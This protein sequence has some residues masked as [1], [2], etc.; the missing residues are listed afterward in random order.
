MKKN[1]FYRED[2]PK[3]FNKKN[4]IGVELG[5]AR[6]DFS[7]ELLKSKK[8]KLLFG[9]DSYSLN[10]HNIDE[11]KFALKNVGLFDNYKLLNMKFEDAL[12]L[13]PDR[14]LDFIYFDGYA[15]TG[16][17]YGKT[18]IKWSKK[19]K[20]NG[21]L[22][23]DDYDA[24]WELNKQIIDQFASDNN[25]K[26]YVTDINK[27]HSYSSWIIKVNKKIK[28][29]NIKYSKVLKYKELLKSYRL[30]TFNLHK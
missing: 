16:Q 27:K 10:Q 21:I 3:L 26:I 18:L 6:G 25:F 19:I 29:K 28:N 11:Y 8:F 9:V 4:L 13:F 24:K 17:D 7:K 22:S 5:V 1:K 15:H 23:G 14:S 30:Y 20:L 2:L 12:D